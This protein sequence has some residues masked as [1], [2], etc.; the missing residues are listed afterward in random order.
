MLQIGCIGC[1]SEY[2]RTGVPVWVTLAA[3]YWSNAD[4]ALSADRS[5]LLEL[6]QLDYLYCW[7]AICG[8]CIC[9]MDFEYLSF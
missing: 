8:G 5:T 4:Q 2:S 3:D 7:R 9:R 1:L 6:E